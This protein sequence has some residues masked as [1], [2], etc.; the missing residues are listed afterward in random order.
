MKTVTT[1]KKTS[2]PDSAS[3]EQ[4]LQFAVHIYLHLKG[5]GLA[6]FCFDGKCHFAVLDL[7]DPLKYRAPEN[8]GVTCTDGRKLTV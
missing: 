2:D 5:I 8:Q 1:D 6:A 3:R 7:S 4:F